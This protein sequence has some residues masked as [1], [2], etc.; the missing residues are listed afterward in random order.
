MDDHQF[1]PIAAVALDTAVGHAG[2]G[3][4]VGVLLKVRIDTFFVI[5]AVEVSAGVDAVVLVDD[6]RR[7]LCDG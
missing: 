6:H 7:P 3:R 5:V 1:D 2:D 4:E